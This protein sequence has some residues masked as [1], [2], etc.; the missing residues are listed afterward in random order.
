MT[1]EQEEIFLEE[2]DPPEKEVGPNGGN[3]EQ[4]LTIIYDYKNPQ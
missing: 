3:M 1:Q 4:I 2:K